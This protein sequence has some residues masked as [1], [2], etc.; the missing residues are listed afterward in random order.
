MGFNGKS[1]YVKIHQDVM[2]QR[3]EQKERFNHSLFNAEEVSIKGCNIFW[4]NFPIN[5]I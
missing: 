3:T 4:E 5:A 2:D 1:M